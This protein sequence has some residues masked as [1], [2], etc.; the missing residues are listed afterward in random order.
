MRLLSVRLILSVVA[1]LLKKKLLFSYYTVKT[2]EHV[3]RSDLERRADLLGESLSSNV[4]H[5]LTKESPH[6][7]QRIVERFANREH[8]VGIA[9]YD[10]A[11]QRLA[12]TPNLVGILNDRPPVVAKAIV[13]NL[14]DSEFARVGNASLYIRVIPLHADNRI[15]G[16]LAIVHDSGY[17]GAETRRLWRES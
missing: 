9:V 10:V 14:P 16:A 13:D 12:V 11:G 3:L 4:E 17:I 5:A 2:E 7:L 8:L 1:G 6:A 15:A